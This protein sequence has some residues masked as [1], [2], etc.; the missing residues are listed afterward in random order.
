MWHKYQL[1]QFPA[2]RRLV[3]DLQYQNA[4]DDALYLPSDFPTSMQRQQLGLAELGDQE[5]K[6]R[7]GEANDALDRVRL[8]IKQFGMNF[9]FKKNQIRGQRDNTQAQTVLK[10][11]MAERNKHVQNYR[12]SRNA[13]LSLGMALDDLTYRPLRDDDLWMKNLANAHKLGDGSKTEP[14]IWTAG[15]SGG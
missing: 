9:D 7:E 11:S 5:Q 13:L 14:W 2:V 3:T 12:A 10:A 4:E 8:A 1:A 15:T 6:L